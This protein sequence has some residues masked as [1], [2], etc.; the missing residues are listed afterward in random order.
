MWLAISFWPLISFGFK[1]NNNLKAGTFSSRKAVHD[2]ELIERD[3]CML[4]GDAGFQ[5]FSPHPT[6]QNIFK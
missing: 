4:Y 3:F 6:P 2:K 5:N 1:R